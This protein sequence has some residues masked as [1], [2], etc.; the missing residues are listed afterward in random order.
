MSRA[1]PPALVPLLGWAPAPALRQAQPGHGACPHHRHQPPTA[2][3]WWG[4]GGR[5]G[6]GPAS[7]WL[8][9]T[10]T[11]PTGTSAAVTLAATSR[12]RCGCATSGEPAR[13]RAAALYVLPSPSGHV[14]RP[15]AAPNLH[16]VPFCQVLKRPRRREPGGDGSSL[17]ASNP[18]QN[19]L[20]EAVRSAKIAVETVVDDWL[21]TYKQDRETG[22]LELVNFIVRSC[23]CRGV[24]T[25]KMFR[26]LQN[27]EIIQQ[28][29]EKFE[30]DSAEY[31]LSLG[32]QPWRRF[33]ATFCE[34]VAAVVRR[35]QYSVVYDEFLM[36]ALISL[37]TGLSDSQVRAFRHTS[38]LAAMKLMTALV[39]VA[40]G[41]SLH[42]E[43]NQR[44]YEA[45]WSKGPGR[46]ATDKL[47]A[48]LEKRRELQEQQE[49]IENMMNAIFKGIFVHRYRDVVPEI[50]A[51]C[52]E[53]LGTWM[54]SYT[55]SF[56]TDGYLKYIGWTLHDKQREVRLQCVKALQ[57]LYCH[58]DTAAHMELFTSR[59][60]TRMVSM[61]LDK[62]PDV[63]VEV[64][65][66][67]TLML[68]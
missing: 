35:C 17:A 33:R 7:A 59:F 9:P 47:E 39:N 43:N 55:A 57:G 6:R 2:R 58:R 34:L 40:L 20:F 4:R 21:E 67:L 29:T 66:L 65:K 60:K 61:V 30:E 15:G 38:T 51:I 68:E 48:L 12:T 1:P 5:R 53:E 44:Q 19:T 45:E 31:P 23:G 41:V 13:H 56:L 36:D 32:T 16:R 22:F 26:H 14:P 62:E 27:S 10:T 24:V 11:V 54:K 3:E 28:L 42:Q 49:E 25:L 52:M 37:L 63:A 46:Q 8:Y 64:V 50:R 18:E